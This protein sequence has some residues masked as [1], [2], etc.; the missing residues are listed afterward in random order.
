MDIWTCACSSTICDNQVIMVWTRAHIHTSI[1]PV[2]G[3]LALRAHSVYI[4]ADTDDMYT[5][6]AHAFVKCKQSSRL[7]TMLVIDKSD[8]SP[9]PPVFM[10]RG[11]RAFMGALLT[12]VHAE[13]QLPPQLGQYGGV[14]L[15]GTFDRIH[16]GHKILLTSAA[17]LARTQFTC[18]VTHPQM[19]KRKVLSELIEPLDVR[20]DSVRQFVGDIDST[21]NL[22]VRRMCVQ[23]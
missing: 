20:I 13:S 10:P 5:K 7:D 21:L 9:P 1:Q 8:D 17:M 6:L 4:D 16:N 2:T 15:G 14:V 23:C 22:K 12:R 19:L 18:G 11:M 3:A